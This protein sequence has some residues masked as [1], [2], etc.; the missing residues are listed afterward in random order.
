[1]N[2]LVTG[3][4]GNLGSRLA[5]CLAERGDRVTVLDLRPEPLE[6][7][8]AFRLCHLL[9]GDIADPAALQP[10]FADGSFDS[11]FHLAALLSADSE[12]DAKRAWRVNLEG[13]RHIL[14]AAAAHGVARVIFASSTASF[15]PGLPPPVQLDSPQWPAS[16]YGATKVA[17]ERLGVY[18][19]HRC[20][21][22][23]RGLRIPAVVAPR[24]AGGGATAF[25]SEV[26]EQAVRN[27]RYEFYVEPAAGRPLIYIDDAVRA[28]LAL[29]D[30]PAEDL[31]R[32]V[33]QV[34]GI[35]ATAREMAAAV[36]ARLPEVDFSYRPDPLR[37]AIARSLPI[38]IDDSH[39]VRDWNWSPRYDLPAMTLR[40]IE[41]LQKESP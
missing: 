9:T 30:A 16:L 27:G 12:R 5:A 6:D 34:A 26:F 22:D 10:I 3:G 28:L 35:P 14:Q 41:E 17:G 8:P 40:M 20:G 1:M 33:Y 15:G 11:V 37:N 4:M 7:S 32:R 36:L 25:C 39:A 24:G 13:A 29:H 21:L 19:H 31:T 18:F 38:H 23:F 2:V